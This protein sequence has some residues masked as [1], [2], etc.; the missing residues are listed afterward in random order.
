MCVLFLEPTSVL[1]N[2]IFE[3]TEVKTPTCVATLP[4]KID[5]SV[6]NCKTNKKEVASEHLVKID[7]YMTIC[8]D[9]FTN[10]SNPYDFA[11]NYLKKVYHK[12]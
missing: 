3:G 8:F 2:A 6:D 4:Y 10:I 7:K 11:K 1:C 12:R 9:L 5:L